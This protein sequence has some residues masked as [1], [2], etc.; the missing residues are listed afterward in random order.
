LNKLYY[1]SA[2][3]APAPIIEIDP[4]SLEEKDVVVNFDTSAPNSLFSELTNPEIEFPH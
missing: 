4:Y 3:I 2:K 1:R